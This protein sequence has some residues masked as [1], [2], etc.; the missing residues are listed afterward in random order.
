LRTSIPISRCGAFDGHRHRS[1][2]RL[3]PG[4]SIDQIRL[5]LYSA[6][7]VRQVSTIYAPDDTYQVIL[8]VDPKYADTKRG[9]APHAGA[10]GRPAAWC[11]STPWPR[12]PTSRRPLTVKPHRPVPAVM[13]S[14]NLAPGVASARR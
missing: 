3:P 9:A 1:R 5:L 4:L 8:E 10:H 6:Y 12:D 14:F 11:R 2:Y 7:G 13:I